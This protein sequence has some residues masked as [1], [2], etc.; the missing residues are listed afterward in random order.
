MTCRRLASSGRRLERSPSVRSCGPFV[1]TRLAAATMGRGPRRRT[2]D[3]LHFRGQRLSTAVQSLGWLSPLQGALAVSHTFGPYQHSDPAARGNMW[4]GS[5]LIR[6]RTWGSRKTC[7]R[8]RHTGTVARPFR[9]GVAVFSPT[10]RPPSSQ[11]GSTWQ[12]VS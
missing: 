12:T 11:I 10:T 6:R 5:Q 2:G 4:L 1:T 3:W 8:C 9:S 7:C